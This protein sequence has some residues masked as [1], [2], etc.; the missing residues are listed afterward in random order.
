MLVAPA[1]EER[2]YF[3][4]RDREQELA[5]FAAPPSQPGGRPRGRLRLSATA[6]VS[7][8]RA[9]GASTP[10]G[11]AWQAVDAQPLAAEPYA[12][13]LDLVLTFATTDYARGPASRCCARRSFASPRRW[14]PR[15]GAVRE[16]RF[17]TR[18]QNRAELE[19]EPRA[20]G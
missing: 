16:R 1:D 15:R 11:V 13:A 3:V 9:A 14:Q 8:A 2:L 12:A 19:S 4:S 18:V 5:D 7:R 20:S 6:A 17:R 10:S